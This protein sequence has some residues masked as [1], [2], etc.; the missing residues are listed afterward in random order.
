MTEKKRIKE[1]VLEELDKD[2]IQAKFGKISETK[3]VIDLTIQ[4]VSKQI[5]DDIEKHMEFWVMN[6]DKAYQKI[7]QKYLGDNKEVDLK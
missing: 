6:E 3:R 5:F 2:S 7:K 4:R 1:E